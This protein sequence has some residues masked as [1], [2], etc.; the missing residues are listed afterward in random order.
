M[1]VRRISQVTQRCGF[2]ST[3]KV[4][5]WPR[6]VWPWLSSYSSLPLYGLLLRVVNYW[7]MIYSILILKE[8]RIVISTVTGQA[9]VWK[10][11]GIRESITIWFS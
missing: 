3:E 8:D 11:T 2:L 7:A 1:K 5:D 6:I 10:V 9:I 4:D